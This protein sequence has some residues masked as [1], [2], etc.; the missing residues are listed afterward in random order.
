M[1]EHP[2]TM[3]VS[4][5]HYPVTNLGFGTR[6]G[7][8][9]QGCTV[10]CRGCIARDTWP[11][12]PAR[13]QP[14]DQVMAWLDQLPAPVDGITISGGE[15]TDQ[16]GALLALL[17]R[18]HA[19]RGAREIDLLLYSGRATAHLDRE[20]GWLRGYVDL[21]IS[22]PFE[23]AAATDCPLRGSPNQLVRTFSELGARR[24]PPETLD[25]DYGR[26]RTHLSVVVGD[27]TIQTVGI[28]LPGDLAALRTRMAERG[29]EMTR[30]S[31]L[32]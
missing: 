26:Q 6:A 18:I 25:A 3:L 8:W 4:R 29:I 30:T 32:M 19:W 14:I 1:S 2:P 9:F 20:F 13:E 10:Y 12:D 21:L 15:P 16:P 28:P 23:L 22:E 11:F 24:Y 7:I 27:G 17:T 5:L 31:W